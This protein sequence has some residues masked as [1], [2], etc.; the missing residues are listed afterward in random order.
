MVLTFREEAATQAAAHLLRRS[1]GSLPYI[2]LLKL[3]YLADRKALLELGRPITFDRYVSMQHGPVLS[4]TY[5]LM[6]AEEAPGEHSYWREHISEPHDYAVQLRSEAP[7]R[8]A[9]SPAQEAVLDAV[10]DEFGG[11]DRWKLVDF[12]HTLPEWQDPHGSSLPLP[13]RDILRAGGVDD[14]AAEAIEHDLLG[15]DSLARLLW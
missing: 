12:T 6:V 8:G 1:G 11:M 14:D 13:I 15:E 9:L 7:P 2:K 3:L 5:D 4:R 10:F